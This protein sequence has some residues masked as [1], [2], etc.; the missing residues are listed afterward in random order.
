MYKMIISL[1][2][3]ASER[4]ESNYLVILDVSQ[5]LVIEPIQQNS[6]WPRQEIWEQKRSNEKN[7]IQQIVSS[8]RSQTK[9]DS[10][11]TKLRG[12]KFNETLNSL[13]VNKMVNKF[14]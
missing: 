3:P 10:I 7:Q 9:T 8:R 5:E 4:L 2:T 11:K 14:R 12:R 6:G 1:M 13:R